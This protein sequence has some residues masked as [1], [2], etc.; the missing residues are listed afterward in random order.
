MTKAELSREPAQ[1]AWRSAIERFQRAPA[2]MKQ[3]RLVEMR[4]AATAAL[5]EASRLREA[6]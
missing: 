1:V 6:A 5:D 4:A 3:I 2:G